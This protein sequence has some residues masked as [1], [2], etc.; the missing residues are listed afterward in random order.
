MPTG[1][2]AGILDGD[3]KDFKT[4]AKKCMRN[5]GAT[6]HMR[7]ESNDV[8]YFPRT[9]GD[10]HTKEIKKA[11]QLLTDSQT[12]S[13]EAIIQ[14][15]KDE[16]TKDKE[17]HLRAIDKNK[18]DSENLNKFLEEARKYNPP[19]EQHKGI[20][21]FMIEQITSTIDFDC[22]N[23]YHAEKLVA[24]DKEME[25][26]TPK[27]VRLSMLEKATKDLRYHETEYAKELKRCNESNEWV[28][29]FIDSLE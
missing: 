29:R 6:I 1:Y 17:Y 24:I 7:D 28:R 18:I 9:P 16:L 3:I 4:F 11:N 25:T 20:K 19:T 21:S 15:R 5:F 27:L 10:Y 2:T 8:E 23:S 12:L 26:I 22:N 14:I 13:D